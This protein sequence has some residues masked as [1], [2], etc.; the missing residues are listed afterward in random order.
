MALI[1]QHTLTEQGRQARRRNGRQSRGAATAPGKERT[2]AANLKHGIYSQ[3]RDQAL[4]SLGED[5]AMLEEFMEGSYEQWRPENRQQSGLVEQL[6][7][8]Q[9]RMGRAVRMQE[10]LAAAQVQKA[11]AAHQQ[12]AEVARARWVEMLETLATLAEH[13]LRPDFYA[14][15]A[16]IYNFLNTFDDE[17]FQPSESILVLLHRLQEPPNLPPAQ[18]PPPDGAPEDDSWLAYL[19]D[20]E[21]QRAEERE[22]DGEQEGEDEVPFPDIPVAEGEERA[23]LRQQLNVLAQEEAQRAEAEG[24]RSLNLPLPQAERDRAVLAANDQ[25]DRLRR[26]EESCTRQFCRLGAF[27]MKIQDRAAARQSP[28]EDADSEDAGHD[29]EAETIGHQPD[30]DDRDKKPAGPPD[31]AHHPH[32]DPPG[33]P[34]PPLQK[35]E[36]AGVSGDVIENTESADVVPVSPIPLGNNAALDGRP[37]DANGRVVPPQPSRRFGVVKLTDLVKHFGVIGQSLEAMRAALRNVKGAPVALG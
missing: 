8:L 30:A 13:A 10:R 34:E 6:A 31:N 12:Q 16:Y 14:S 7:H 35:R 32:G 36:N 15:P 33:T 9:W 4:R 25:L 19:N 22:E 2:R 3:E 24:D 27:L 29:D 21:E 37:L 26:E 5:P 28:I 17:M 11:E 23:G 18:E 20:L 1:K